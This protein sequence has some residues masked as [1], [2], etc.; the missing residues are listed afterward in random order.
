MN[1]RTLFTYLKKK[2][3]TFCV[4]YAKAYFKTAT[5]VMFGCIIIID[6]A[7]Y[8]SVLSLFESMQNDYYYLVN[9]NRNGKLKNTAM[10]DEPIIALVVKT[11]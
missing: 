1:N 8:G 11:P 3:N 2:T 6:G 5:H 10:P 7:C 9:M 4:W